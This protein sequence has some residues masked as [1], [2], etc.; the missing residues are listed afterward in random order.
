[1]RRHLVHRKNV[2]MVQSRCGSRFNFEAVQAAGVGG[3]GLGQDLDRDLSFQPGVTRAIH[4]AHSAHAQGR[5]NFILPENRALDYGH[6]YAQ[7]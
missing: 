2:G 3:D 1:M 4:L 7:L 6:R 5:E